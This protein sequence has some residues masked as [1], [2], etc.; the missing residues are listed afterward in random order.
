MKPGTRVESIP[1]RVTRSRAEARA[2]YNHLSRWYGWIS[3]SETPFRERGTALLAAQAGQRVL[4]I[5]FGTGTCLRDFA[6]QVGPL[7]LACGIDLSPGMARA[8][9]KTLRQA[10]LERRAALHLGD[11]A[12]LPYPSGTFD[13]LLMAFT[14]EL[15]DTSEILPVLAECRRVLK[16]PGRLCVVSLA[17]PEPPGRAVRMYEWFHRRFPRLVDCRPIPAAEYLRQAGFLVTRVEPGGLWGLPVECIL[18]NLA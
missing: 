3:A 10:G 2:T 14:L 9:Q 8:A 12:A 13:A 15:F 18:A 1:A 7:G 5:G 4:E 16:R 11:A 17:R 6:R